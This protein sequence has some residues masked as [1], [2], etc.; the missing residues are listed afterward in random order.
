MY[1]LLIFVTMIYNTSEQVLSMNRIE[2]FLK[3]NL[4]LIIIYGLSF[5]SFISRNEY[6]SYNL[7]ITIFLLFLLSILLIFFKNTIFAIPILFAIM[8]GYNL[9]N[10]NLNTIDGFDFIYLIPIFLF[11]SI[12]IHI[13]RFKPKFKVGVLTK[14]YFLIALAYIASIFYVNITLT[15]LQLSLV[16][17]LYLIIYQFFRQ[18]VST[19]ENYMMRLLFFASLLLVAELGFHIGLG[20]FNYNLDKPLSERLS[21]GM[22]NIW[23]NGDFGWGNLNEVVIQI[24]LLFG[25]HFYFI[26]KH[27]KNIL[28]WLFPLITAFIIFISASRGGYISLGISLVLYLVYISYTKNKW[29][30]LNMIY[31]LIFVGLLIYQYRTVIDI[32]FSTFVQGGLDNI[33]FFS[34]SRISLYRNA[35]E[36]YRKFPVFG[37]GWESLVDFENPDRIQVFHSTFFHTLAVMGTFGLLIL[38]YYFNQTFRFLLTYKTLHKSMLLVGIFASQIHGLI[39]NTM[40]M[41]VYTLSTLW[42][43]SMLESI[44]EQP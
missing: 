19:D 41:L 28:F 10:P 13:I 39:D 35:L 5:L 44:E 12:I 11:S 27:P 20:F 21:L 15:Y 14:P 30:I 33:D 18:T 7:Y 31:A 40:Y 25:T 9:K 16:G 17:F 34:T 32:A 4:Y 6:Q 3:S 1:L 23:Y 29:A 43:F 2:I 22:S 42:V 8:Y 37:G 38:I 26:V 24:I 36:V